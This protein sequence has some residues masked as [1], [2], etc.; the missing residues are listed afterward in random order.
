[1]TGRFAPFARLC[2]PALASI[3]LADNPVITHRFLADPNG[4]VYGNRLYAICSNDDENGNGYDMA[5]S[6]LIST[7]DMAN[8]SDHGEVYYSPKD[9][10]WSNRAYAPT[11]I[12]RNGKVYYYI[13]NAGSAIGVFVA[14]RPEGPLKDP[15]GK[16]L[17]TGSLC[18]GVAWCFDPDIFVDDDGQAW[19]VY[20]GGS[21]SG[22]DFGQN[23]RIIKVNADMVSTSGSPLRVSLQS[24]FEGPFLHKYKGSYYLSYPMSGNSNIGLSMSSS[25]TSGW[26]Y[27]GSILDNPSLNGKNVNL[28]NNSHESMFE[29]D[30][31]WYMMYHDRRISNAVYKRSVNID[32]LVYNADGTI[33]KVVP[34][35]GLAQT[36]NFDPYDSIPAV[37]YSRQRN[38]SAYTNVN[39]SG[40]A[41]QNLLVPR[42]SGAWMRVS[43]ADF[44]DGAKEFS[45]HGGGTAA[46][47]SVEIRSDSAAGTLYGTCAIPKSG[48]W[49]TLSTSTCP[50][51]GLSGVKDV[52][53]KFT[54]TDSNAVADWWRFV[55]SSTALRP[56]AV[57]VAPSARSYS[58]FD[59]RGRP[60]R[61]FDAPADVVPEAAWRNQART[62]PTGLYM[63]EVRSREGVRVERFLRAG[64]R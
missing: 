42:R 13:P 57:A 48:S 55:P 6:V 62:L 34:T 1:M 29:Y 53:L 30:K 33:Q 11:A 54:G 4:F 22:S 49:T 50:L 60:V 15:L 59:V 2:V 41:R 17:V 16:A 39:N 7:R 23:I 27:K 38:V 56:P 47:A 44:G 20:G 51:T 14:D 45:I 24:S 35:T 26:T 64:E 25:P 46:S 28:G 36:R 52:Y 61:T 58:V 9:T 10:R 37:T 32:K 31:S 5:G 63:V 8:W 43:G 19:L 40:T 3:C 18:D 12:A 21:S